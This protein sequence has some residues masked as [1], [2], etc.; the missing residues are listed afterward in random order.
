MIKKVIDIVKK[1]IYFIAI[2]VTVFFIANKE[3]KDELSKIKDE[4]YEKDID[5][6]VD[7]L[8]TWLS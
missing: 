2:S 1:V 8:N 4:I 3:D 5:D 7:S 6:V